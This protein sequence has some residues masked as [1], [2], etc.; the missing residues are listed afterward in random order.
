MP[1]RSLA[2]VRQKDW[3]R[4]CHKLGLLVETQHGKGGHVLVKHPRDGRKY[5]IQYH[6]NRLINIKLFK[7]LL[8]WGFSE[9]GIWEA[10][11]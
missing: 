5:T 3:I 10:L 8:D 1:K 4:A 6:L 11:S 2:D 9:E 7:V